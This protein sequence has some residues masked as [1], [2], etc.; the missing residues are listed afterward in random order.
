MNYYCVS[1]FSA[2]KRTACVA[3]ALVLAYPPVTVSGEKSSVSVITS[4]R[5]FQAG[6]V[7]S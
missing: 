2:A 3:R 7:R 5:L 1:P 4:P 6:H